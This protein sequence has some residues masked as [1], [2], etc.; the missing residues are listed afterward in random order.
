MTLLTDPVSPW[1]L[2]DGAIGVCTLSSQQGFEAI[3]AC[4]KPRV[5]GQPFYAGWG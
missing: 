4:H 1:P 2:F 3:F 5:Y